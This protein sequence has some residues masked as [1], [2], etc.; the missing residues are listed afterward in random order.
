MVFLGTVK[1]FC[2]GRLAP[3]LLIAPGVRI[4]KLCLVLCSVALGTNCNDLISER[5]RR[6]RLKE[7]CPD[8]NLRERQTCHGATMETATTVPLEM[9]FLRAT[10]RHLCLLH[11]Q[12]GN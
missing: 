3:A 4:W 9:E 10:S 7:L 11:L 12:G 6:R 8:K 2:K 1:S 5:Y